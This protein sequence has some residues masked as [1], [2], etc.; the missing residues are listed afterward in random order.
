MLFHV[1]FAYFGLLTYTIFFQ[2]GLPPVFSRV[3]DA[4]PVTCPFRPGV[5]T[6]QEYEAWYASLQVTLCQTFGPVEGM[7]L[8]NVRYYS[9]KSNAAFMLHALRRNARLLSL[10]QPLQPLPRRANCA[11]LE[12]VNTAAACASAA[13]T[14]E[15]R[16]TATEPAAAAGAEE[17][18]EIVTESPPAK[19]RRRREQ[20]LEERAQRA[21]QYL[22]LHFENPENAAAAGVSIFCLYFPS[23]H[24]FSS[25]L[26]S[27]KSSFH[28]QSPPIFFKF[29]CLC[30]KCVFYRS[31]AGRPASSR[32]KFEKSYAELFST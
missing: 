9:D 27:K 28:R 15:D 1:Q 29:M 6:G 20:T 13:S 3:L 12:L 26:P 31:S 17:E 4:I 22:P 14:G 24:P 5:W 11:D 16:K 18:K 10:G 19:R 25:S 30:V 23:V 8:W 2:L 32:E 7:R 21:Q